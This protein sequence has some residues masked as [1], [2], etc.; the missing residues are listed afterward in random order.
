MDVRHAQQL[1]Y[2]PGFYTG[3][4]DG[5][6]GPLTDK[7]IALVETRY[8][9]N[10]RGW[11]SGRRLIAAAQVMLEKAGHEP[12]TIDGKYGPNTKEAL[13]SW[14]TQNVTGK[15]VVLDRVPSPAYS[16][17]EEQVRFPKQSDMTAFYGPP[18][19][20]KCTSGRVTFPVPMYLA[21]D[22]GEKVKTTTCHERVA[23]AFQQV[24]DE[25]VRHYGESEF[26]NLRLDRWGGCFNLRKMRGGT[27]WS[28]H[29]YGAAFDLDPDNN[30]L[31]WGRDRA[32][33]ARQEYE[34]FINICESVGLVSLGRA[35]NMDWMHFQAA[36][37]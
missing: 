6:H 25:T 24:F 11:P 36:R 1:M 10:W 7:A 3:H 8:G 9:Y 13:N 19:N 28:T 14:L 4:I 33:F 34:A 2:Y 12:G 37:L 26:R 30:Q 31:R 22:L 17:T 35:A 32:S 16:P 5:D 21:W 27:S 29:A 20:P 18:G 23:V 15:P